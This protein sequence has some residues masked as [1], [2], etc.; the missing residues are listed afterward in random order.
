[1]SLPVVLRPQAL[2]SFTVTHLPGDGEGATCLRPGRAPAEAAAPA[3]GSKSH[4]TK[5]QAL[6]HREAPERER[7]FIEVR[8]DRT[9]SRLP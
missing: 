4:H 3:V 6:H 2:P 9:L 8:G 7:T 5:C 1:M